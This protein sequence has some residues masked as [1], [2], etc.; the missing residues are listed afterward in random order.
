MSTSVSTPTQKHDAP[1]ESPYVPYEKRASQHVRPTGFWKDAFVTVVLAKLGYFV[2]FISGGTLLDKRSTREIVR[3]YWKDTFDAFGYLA[4]H[5]HFSNAQ[6]V[7]FSFGIIATGV[8]LFLV[9]K[10]NEHQRIK[11][12]EGLERA[13]EYLATNPTET[14]TAQM[15]QIEEKIREIRKLH[16]ARDKRIGATHTADTIALER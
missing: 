11:T 8:K 2:G 13:H 3:I 9:W 1:Q 7:G 10:K 16:E 15:S 6:K 5:N 4:Q 12:H 14:Q